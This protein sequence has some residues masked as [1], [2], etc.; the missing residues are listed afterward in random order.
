[1]MTQ[2][3]E[4]RNICQAQNLGVSLNTT[5]HQQSAMFTWSFGRLTQRL[6]VLKNLCL[7]MSSKLALSSSGHMAD[8]RSMKR[9]SDRRLHRCPPFLSAAVL[10]ATCMQQ[11]SRHPVNTQCF[12]QHFQGDTLRVF[13]Q[14]T[15]KRPRRQTP[16]RGIAIVD[17]RTNPR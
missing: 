16:T 15:L 4:Q 2:H 6:L 1:M 9:P 7:E 14:G 17:K 10:S 13:L 3:Q 8:S 5:P 12:W 11:P